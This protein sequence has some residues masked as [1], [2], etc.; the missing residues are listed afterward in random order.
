VPYHRCRDRFLK[1]QTASLGEGV[2]LAKAM[3]LLHSQK[4]VSRSVGIRDSWPRE[5]R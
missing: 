1:R 2:E 3:A 4:V 5:G